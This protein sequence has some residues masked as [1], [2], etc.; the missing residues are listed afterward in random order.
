MTSRLPPLISASHSRDNRSLTRQTTKRGLRAGAPVVGLLFGMQRGL[1][2]DV[3]DAIE[4]H[5][6]EATKVDAAFLE[7]SKSLYTEVYEDRD[8]VGW[9]AVAPAPTA[10]EEL[11]DNR[12]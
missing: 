10:N 2:V 4:V 9:Y 11:K 12:V 1:E 5:L 3:V 6:T 7:Q 8:L